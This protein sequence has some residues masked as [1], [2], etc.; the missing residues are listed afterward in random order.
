MGK[1]SF[2]AFFDSKTKRSGGFHV[3]NSG[4]GLAICMGENC[5]RKREAM[6]A[7]FCKSYTRTYLIETRI[8]SGLGVV[9]LHLRGPCGLRRTVSRDITIHKTLKEPLEYEVPWSS[10]G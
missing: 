3:G 5:A 1:G 8:V 10:P 4:C 2:E 7:P 9:E 6:K